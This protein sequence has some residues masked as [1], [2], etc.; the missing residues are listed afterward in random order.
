[1]GHERPAEVFYHQSA[2]LWL[3]VLTKPFVTADRPWLRQ[4]VDAYAQWTYAANG[5]GL[6]DGDELS[7]TSN[8]WND[9][10]F[11]ILANCIAGMSVE[12]A[13]TVVSA[14]AALPDRHFFDVSVDFL[15]SLD[16]VFF[17][18]DVH[19]S[20]VVF[21]MRAKMADRLM[22]SSGWR[23]QHGSRS[24]GIEMHLGPAIAIHFFN[25]L[26]FGRGARCYVYPQGIPR[27]N[28]FIPIMRKLVENGP[29]PC[30]AIAALNLLEVAPQIEQLPLVLALANA[31]LT[32]YGTDRAFWDEHNTGRRLCAWFENMLKQHPDAFD[33]SAPIRPDLDRVL[34]SLV[35]LGVAEA[36]RLELAL[37][38]K[39]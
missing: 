19:D 27:A 17:G 1:V 7:Q 29:S 16:A 39:H 31:A 18:N 11:A 34:A 37:M 20:S 14:I 33:T 6:D 38:P 8:Q 13:G 28:A 4:F 2:A 23:Q 5:A 30:T 12:E 35:A 3:S 24:S 32:E 22:S 21:A 26:L 15:R 10:Y 36:R 9:A 25:D